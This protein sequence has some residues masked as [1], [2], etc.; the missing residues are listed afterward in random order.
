MRRG[1]RAPATPFTVRRRP[2]VDEAMVE[3][4]QRRPIETEL[5]EGTRLVVEDCDVSL[6]DQTLRLGEIVGTK[7]VQHQTALVAIPGE[8]AGLS[9]AALVNGRIDLD[10][11]C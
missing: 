6:D 2:R 7:D 1:Q 10:H 4:R 11:L 9:T 5:L 8:I 3:P